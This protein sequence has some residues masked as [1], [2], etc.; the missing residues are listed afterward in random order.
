MSPLIDDSQ[1]HV[2]LLDIEGTTTPVDF[3]YKTL[4]PYARHR[5]ESFIREHY[6][7]SE[8]QA[9]LA[10]LR[11]QHEREESDEAQPPSWHD[12]TDDTRIHSVVKYVHWL[13]DRD[14]KG[15]PLKT[16]Q[17]KIWQEGYER[18]E[19]RGQVYVDVPS[20]FARWR[21]QG[22]EI[23]IYSSGSEL[24]QQLLFRSTAAGDLTVYISAYFD[25][26]IGAKTEASSYMK[27]AESLHRKSNEVLFISDAVKEIDAA[28]LAS[29]QTLLCMRDTTAPVVASVGKIVGTFDEVLPG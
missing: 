27:I 4:F 22:R 7:D 29:M 8:T 6:R 11:S 25:T 23:C 19:L 15:T 21:A 16:L 1:I 2:I 3:V 5:V 12:Q 13:M 20:A 24:A 28:R 18:G 26:R 17:G 14:R 10:E 9:L